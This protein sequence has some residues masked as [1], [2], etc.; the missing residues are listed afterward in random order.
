MIKTSLINR[1]R[2]I[3]FKSNLF[4]ILKKGTPPS[5]GKCAFF[6]DIGCNHSESSWV[7]FFLIQSRTT[8]MSDNISTALIQTI[9][10]SWTNCQG[11]LAC[12]L[13]TVWWASSG[14]LLTWIIWK[15]LIISRTPRIIALI[16]IIS[17]KGFTIFIVLFVF[18]V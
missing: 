8:K 10:A 4:L 12:Q 3:I 14:E 5:Y 16:A 11:S 17:A 13:T 7:Y 15:K 1:F 6:L 2:D 18:I 9:L